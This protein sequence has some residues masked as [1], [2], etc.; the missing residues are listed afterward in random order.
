MIKLIVNNVRT[1]ILDLDPYLAEEI[2][3]VTSYLS[4]PEILGIDLNIFKNYTFA[5]NQKEIWNGWVH[6]LR[7]NKYS[8]ETSI[9]SGLRD[10]VCKKLTDLNVAF[11]VEDKRVSPCENKKLLRSIPPIP[12]FDYQLEAKKCLIA[13]PDCVVECPPRSGKTRIMLETCRE[14]SFP[15]LWIA[16]T[17]AIVEQTIRAGLEFLP[18]E[19]IQRVTSKNWTE[20]SNCLINITT[21]AGMLSLPPEYFQTREVLVVDECHHFVADNSWA[22]KLAQNTQHIY[23]RKGMSGTFYRSSGDDLSLLAFIGRVGYSISSGALLERGRLIP[24]YVCFAP[25]KGPKVHVAPGSQ[26]LGQSGVGTLGLTNHSYRNDVVA[27]V[28]KHLES[29]GRTVL[30]LVTTKAQG[31]EIKERLDEFFPKKVNTEFSAV[32]FVSTDKNKL[33]IQKIFASFVKGQ[34][35]KILIGTSMVGEGI[36]LPPADA[37]VYAAGKK[38]AVQYVQSLYRVCTASEGKTYGLVIDF[39]DKQHRTL[40]DHSRAR[41]KIISSDPVFKPTHLNN[42]EEFTAWAANTVIQR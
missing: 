20:Q 23:H 4:Q 15:T 18:K 40:L 42:L 41:W 1:E 16:P 37:L 17:N 28:S 25:I 14:L 7:K 3:K 19:D 27:E 26:F 32:E 13:Q 39:I 35:V 2:D 5:D 36:D 30:I 22:K 33:T 12:L 38:A 8:G 10:I 34:E 29:L 11:F 9:P 31:Y 6:F 24:T 21:S